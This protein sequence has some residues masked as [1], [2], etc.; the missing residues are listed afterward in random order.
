MTTL[1]MTPGI[2]EVR[3]AGEIRGGA[4]LLGFWITQ[5]IPVD[6]PLG[7]SVPSPEGIHEMQV[8][9]FVPVVHGGLSATVALAESMG[10]I[11]APAIKGGQRHADAFALLA[12]M[13][14]SVSDDTVKGI[15]D[16]KTKKV[17]RAKYPTKGTAMVAL[18][19]AA[20]EEMDSSDDFRETLE[21]AME[22]AAQNR[23]EREIAAAKARAEKLEA[24]AATARRDR[25]RRKT[26][27]AARRAALL[28]TVIAAESTEPSEG[29]AE[30]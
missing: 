7:A 15:T 17:T 30:E 9:S 4:T 28:E 16:K 8:A 25:L 14:S 10:G 21:D 11:A 6:G 20:Q 2:F 13:D 1:K 23:E 29:G 26:A 18:Q 27:R 12:G 19:S 5:T 3:N 24:D 22:E